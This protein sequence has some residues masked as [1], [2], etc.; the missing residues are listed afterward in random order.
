M[1]PFP[2]PSNEVKKVE[3]AI[4]ESKSKIKK[5][6]DDKMVFRS[7]PKLYMNPSSDGTAYGYGHSGNEFSLNAMDTLL[8]TEKNKNKTESWNKL[9]KTVKIQKLHMFAEKYG[10]EFGLP[11]K[12]IK[13]LKMFFIECLEKNKL[14]KT[15]D[16]VYSKDTCEIVSIP[17]LHF[18]NTARHFTLKNMDPKRVSTMKALTPRAYSKM[19]ETVA[20]DAEIASASASE[21]IDVSSS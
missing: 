2:I 14:S 17:S 18:N 21:C 4:K 16:M 10:K 5:E 15:K 6:H 20:A 13:T 9:D 12:D 3:D 11:M 8:E 19:K 1:F 7:S